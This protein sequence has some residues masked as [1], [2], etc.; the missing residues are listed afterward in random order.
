MTSPSVSAPSPASG[1]STLSV[2]DAA[3][4]EEACKKSGLIWIAVPGARDRAAWHVW[5]EQ[6]GQGAVYVVVG[7]GE[8]SLPGLADGITVRVTVRSKDKGGR[9]ASWPGLV[10]RITPDG[11]EWAAVV[12][13]LHSKR[14]NAHDGE[15]QPERW[16][17]N[18]AIFRIRPHGALIEGPRRYSPASG[19]APVPPSPATT[20]SR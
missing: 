2:P 17:I 4:V 7:G 14:L 13:V 19:A 20:R 18:S 16:A 6:D 12:P 1:P 11:E 9:L 5:H 3:L 8:Q 15:A 10:S